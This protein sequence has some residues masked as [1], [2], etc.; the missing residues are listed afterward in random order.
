MAKGK[1]ISNATLA[2]RAEVQTNAVSTATAHRN[3]THLHAAG[4]TMTT[5]Q[6]KYTRCSPFPD[7]GGKNKDCRISGQRRRSTASSNSYCGYRV[8]SRTRGASPST[9]SDTRIDSGFRSTYMLHL[10]Q[11][12]VLGRWCDRMTS[13]QQIVTKLHEQSLTHLT[14]YSD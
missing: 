4:P 13:S 12:E 8:T 11:F 5:N 9:P 10:M 6:P 3:R 7:S 14:C 1:C 2:T